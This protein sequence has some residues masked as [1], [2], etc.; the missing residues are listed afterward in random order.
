MTR[1][2]GWSRTALSGAVALGS[3]IAALVAPLIGPVLDRQGARVM[4][5][6]AVRCRS[7]SPSSPSTSSFAWAA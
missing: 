5:C 7:S 2:F 4:L 3:I 6:T 1:G